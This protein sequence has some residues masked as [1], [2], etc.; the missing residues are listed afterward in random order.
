[1]GAAA[2]PVSMRSERDVRRVFFVDGN[3]R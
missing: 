2:R 1:M 3:R